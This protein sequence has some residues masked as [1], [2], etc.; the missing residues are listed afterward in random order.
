VGA[1]YDTPTLKL[2]RRVMPDIVLGTPRN[3]SAPV[4][5]LNPQAAEL[6]DAIASVNPSVL[7]M[8]SNRGRAIYFPSK[9]ILGQTA[10]ARDMRI[11]AT[12]GT[13]LEDDGSPLRLG[14]LEELVDLPATEFL[15]APSYGLPGLRDRWKQRIIANNPGLAHKPISRPVVTHALTHGLYMAG[16]LFLDRGQPLLLPHLYW[17]NYGLVFDNSWGAKLTTFNTFRDGGFDVE[18]LRAA[19]QEGPIGKRV[20][21]LNFP[22]NPTGYTVTEAEAALVK[23]ALVEAAAAGNDVVAIVDDAYFGLVFEEGILT[24]SIFTDLAD[25]HERLMA[26]KIDGATKEDYVWGFRV[27]FMTFGVKGGT[28]AL[29]AALEDKAAGAIR[30]SISNASR[31]TQS[32]LLQAFDHADYA[33][34]KQ[35]KVRTLRHRYEK[36]RDILAAH[37]EYAETFTPLP[38]NSGY[39]MC[40]ELIGADPQAVRRRLLAA[41]DTG[42]IVATGLVR[43]AF[44][45]A[46]LDLLDELFANLYRA[47]LDVRGA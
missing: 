34:Q 33:T 14:C 23:A 31:I 35:D 30:G 21:L 7:R 45:S 37:P 29:Y 42:L 27:G 13:A 16:Y 20:V 10:E 24:R 2:T 32:L 5:D 38:F 26:V 43:V 39:F 25:A 15:Y 8:L 46:P 40:V 4:I 9:G 36:V 47:V 3:R 1:Q 44:S 28:P 18:A 41:Y 19:L 6:N 12:I 22:N 17:G 11:N